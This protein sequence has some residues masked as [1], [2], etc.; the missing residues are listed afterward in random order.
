VN[1]AAVAEEPQL[2]WFEIQHVPSS[3]QVEDAST[4]QV[5]MFALNNFLTSALWTHERHTTQALV[6]CCLRLL[7]V[8]T[9]PTGSALFLAV[10]ARSA[11]PAGFARISSSA[12]SGDA[13]KWGAEESERDEG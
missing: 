8:R 12:G 10:F 13:G 5:E 4:H 1:V 9:S 3:Y 11:A 7:L 2:L 6:I